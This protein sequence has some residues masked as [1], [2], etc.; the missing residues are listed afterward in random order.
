MCLLR[1]RRLLFTR[2]RAQI[3]GHGDISFVVP[4]VLWLSLGLSAHDWV[5]IVEHALAM[6]IT[7]SS[8]FAQ[9]FMNEIIRA[10][11]AKFD[12]A[13]AVLRAA[14]TDQSRL[15]WYAA[16]D[17]LAARTGR[18]E[19][20]LYDAR[21][22]TDDSFFQ[23]V[24]ID[25]AIRMLGLWHHVTSSIQLAMAKPAK[26]QA[27]SALLW[28]GL[29]ALVTLGAW[30]IP[31]GKRMRAVSQTSAI[32]GAQ[33]HPYGELRELNG[34]LEHL[35][36]FAS[37]ELGGGRSLMFGMYP[38]GRTVSSLGPT[39]RVKVSDD[40]RRACVR[41]RRVLNSQPA[42]STLTVALGIA[43]TRGSITVEM[44]SDAAKGGAPRPGLGG[45]LH[46][47]TW[48]IPLEPE[49]V[50]GPLEI[51]I[52]VLE[53]AAIVINFII[54]GPLLPDGVDIIVFSDSAT[55]CDA[56][57]DHT[58]RAPLMQFLLLQLIQN[59]HFRRVVGRAFIQHG[60]GETNVVGDGKSRGYD[61][62]VES[63]FRQLH[64]KHVILDVPGEALSLLRELRARNRA[65]K[66][67]AAAG[68]PGPAT[69]PEP[70]NHDSARPVVDPHGNGVRIGESDTPAP[71]P[72]AQR[73]RPSSAPPAARAPVLSAPPAA[74]APSP[75][76]GARAPPVSSAAP[77]AP[78]VAPVGSA[79][80]NA[81]T[82][83]PTRPRLTIATGG[84]PPLAP[85]RSPRSA[86]PSPRGGGYV[87]PP[88]V[89]APRS[90]ADGRSRSPSPAPERRAPRSRS[91]SPPAVAH[92]T[93]RSAEP[94][95][96]LGCGASLRRRAHRTG[97]LPTRG[98]P[99]A[100]RRRA[101]DRAHAN[102]PRRARTGAGSV[103]LSP[104][105][106]GLRHPRPWR[107]PPAASG[108][109]AQLR[110]TPPRRRPAARARFVCHLADAR[111]ARPA[112]QRPLA[113]RT[114]S[115]RS[116]LPRAHRVAAR[117][118]R[119]RQQRQ[120][121]VARRRPRVAPMEGLLQQPHGHGRVAQRRCR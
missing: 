10:F 18:H 85:V 110:A 61:D 55:S 54:C 4:A 19:A 119:R 21:G 102:S 90:A 66:L 24:G 121:D 57:A 106:L 89:A 63:I 37:D 41:W 22:Y 50:S 39:D 45:H 7:V 23:C 100:A 14:E 88:P 44:S 93:P 48:H 81:P 47:H 78:R 105:R 65:L 94:P 113:P 92:P 20:R 9:R 117:R 11:C 101:R 26:R 6:G 32:I 64:V 12:A 96:V 51:S 49:D 3:G 109:T 108:R 115:G 56:L 52:P 76:F 114:P 95:V 15:D 58:A 16:R 87:S 62:V 5:H 40:M 99:T 28:L 79:R 116:F 53:L 98:P 74:R 83:A 70:S 75:P 77:I 84:L 91:P 1:L 27:G 71:P 34:L 69:A 80:P 86:A 17:R 36:P 111:T 82:P 67:L 107:R 35:R 73:P 33:S 8:N 118:R 103:R 97:G 104:A 68:V 42:V 46:G 25:R 30:S 29:R 2:Q 60:Y 31:P 120:L 72:L 59:V 13:E 112:A 43:P 38:L